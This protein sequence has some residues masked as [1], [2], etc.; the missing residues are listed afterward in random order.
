MWPWAV[1]RIPNRATS[2]CKRVGV[3]TTTLMSSGLK[4][5]SL[6][7]VNKLAVSWSVVIYP[8]IHGRSSRPVALYWRPTL[9][10]S[11]VTTH[12]SL[13]SEVKVSLRWFIP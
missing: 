4:F 3:K 8:F 6:K 12:L 10:T 11:R 1:F 5:D 13:W 7:L 9:A 2:R